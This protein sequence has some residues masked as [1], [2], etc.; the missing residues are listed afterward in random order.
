VLGGFH[1]TSLAAGLPAREAL[2]LLSVHGKNLICV[3][4]ISEE[5]AVK[6]GRLRVIKQALCCMAGSS[7][8]T[9]V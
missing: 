3:A 1:P 6:K 8:G 4:G 9:A 7:G 5:R 2:V